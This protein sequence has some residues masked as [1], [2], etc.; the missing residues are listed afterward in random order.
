MFA[1]KVLETLRDGASHNRTAV[2][3]EDPRAAVLFVAWR[4]TH[5]DV[6]HLR[7]GNY[8]TP[9]LATASE[10][11]KMGVRLAGL[12]EIDAYVREHVDPN[13]LG[14]S[15]DRIFDVDVE[16]SYLPGILLGTSAA[17]AA[18]LPQAFMVNLD[19]CSPEERQLLSKAW[20]RT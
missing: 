18:A 11:G 1:E 10:I 17:E 16:F 4:G 19:L 20:P 7:S 15:L 2:S 13:D 3:P 9:L 8:L 14:A 12:L 5:K 6:M